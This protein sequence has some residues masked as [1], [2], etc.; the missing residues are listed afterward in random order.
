MLHE[1]SRVGHQPSA[2]AVNS[3][4]FIF[5]CFGPS[6]THKG[7]QRLRILCLR[8]LLLLLLLLLPPPP[9]LRRLLLLLLVLLL[10][11]LLLLLLQHPQKV[12]AVLSFVHDPGNP[13]TSLSCQAHSKLLTMAELEHAREMN[14]AAHTAGQKRWASPK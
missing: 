9:L 1:R 14:I 7:S 11:L 6:S 8:Q 2:I 12:A 3:V 10:R 4:R 13:L 5:S